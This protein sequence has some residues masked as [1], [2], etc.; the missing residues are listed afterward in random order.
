M[1]D[2]MYVEVRRYHIATKASIEGSGIMLVGEPA[3]FIYDRQKKELY[4][5]SNHTVVAE[6]VSC[7]R[8]PRTTA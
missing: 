8:A 1:A 6:K 3:A 2:V 7:L 4:K 5:T